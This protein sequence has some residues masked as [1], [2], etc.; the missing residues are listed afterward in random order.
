MSV[1]PTHLD[2]ARKRLCHLA[3]LRHRTDSAD[4]AITAAAAEE[5]DR[6][7]A[8]LPRLASRVHLDPA[9]AD[10]YQRGILDVGKLRTM[11]GRASAA[12]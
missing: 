4:R 7:Q 9:A 12:A 10:A 3:G 5:L 11:L 1:P 8:E 2:A 6:L